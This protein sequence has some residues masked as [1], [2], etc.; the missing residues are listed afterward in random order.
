M[1]RLILAFALLVASVSATS[2]Q[3][4]PF[5]GVW[6]MN[7]TGQDAANVYWLEVKEVDGKLT[8]LFLNRTAHPQPPGIVKI[9]NGELVFQNTDKDNKPTGPEYRAKFE[10]GKLIGRH[11]VTQQG[12]RG[13]DGTRGP[14]T[15]REVNWIG[16]R[17]PAFPPSNANAA[18]KWGTPV[19]LHDSAKPPKALEEIWGAQ[20]TR[21]VNWTV[22]AEG[23]LA[24]P[25]PGG[26]NLVSKEKFSD[27][28]VNVE[29]KLEPHSN[30]G[31]YLRGRYELQVLDDIA[32][33]TTAKYQTQ[34]A[35]YGRTPPSVLASKAPGE[36]QTMEATIAGNRVTVLLNGQKVHD[37]AVIGGITGG[38]LDNDELAPGPLM[39]QGDHGRI[40]IRKVVVTPIVK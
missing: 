1:K 24:N 33:T 11:M 37:N 16:T 25:A 28:K 14:S 26:V 18:H 21:P 32:D 36:W 34:A 22:D 30:S 5:L 27:F 19:V 10:N 23:F 20:G 2:A 40:W 38:A 4:N 31:I 39:I 35:I 13:A 3:T 15:Q 8:A 12:A 7:G 6:N 17:P 9:E 29:F